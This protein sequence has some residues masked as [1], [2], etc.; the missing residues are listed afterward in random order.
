MSVLQMAASTADLC[1]VGMMGQ[2]GREALDMQLGGAVSK[3]CPGAMEE[4]HTVLKCRNRL[5]WEEKSCP[6]LD[7]HKCWVSA[8]SKQECMHT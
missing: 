2:K 3:R 4:T 5:P 6:E 8:P 1:T 7:Q